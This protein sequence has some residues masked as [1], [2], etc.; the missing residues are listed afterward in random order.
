MK[1]VSLSY[2]ASF[3]ISFAAI[4]A[5]PVLG[6]TI[7][8]DDDQPADYPAIQPAIQAAVNGDTILVRDGTYTGAQNRALDFAGK[9]ITL[10]SE[11]GPANC[12]IDCES[13]ARAFYFHTSE[14]AAARLEG[15]TIRN[16]R[17]AVDG[18][19]IYIISASPTMV[20][21]VFSTNQ[22]VRYGGAIY[23]QS[24]SP[25]LDR[26][27][28]ETN[29]AQFGAGIFCNSATPKILDCVVSGNS[30]TDNGGGIHVWNNSN[31]TILRCRILENTS[32][33]HGGGIIFDTA[34]GTMT[35]SLLEDNHARYGGGIAVV[36]NAQP[37]ISRC[38]IRGNMSDDVGGGVYAVHAGAR[39]VISSCLI[40]VN[41]AAGHGAGICSNWAYPTL[42]NCT[43]A[44]NVSDAGSGGYCSYQYAATFS[45]CILWGNAPATNIGPATITYSDVQGGSAGTGNRDEDPLF[46]NAL[47]GEYHL[48]AGSPCFNVGNNAAAGIP[49][50]DLDGKMRAMGTA[51]DLGA[52][53]S[54][55]RILNVP[56]QYPTIQAGIDAATTGDTVL[57]ADGVYSEMVRL[58]NGKS[59]TVRSL[60]GPQNCILDG[61]WTNDY[62]VRF[63][64][65]NSTTVFRGFTVRGWSGGG[66]GEFEAPIFCYSASPTIRDCIIRDNVNSTG[67][68]GI[69][70]ISNSSPTIVDCT[71]MGNIGYNG[72]GILCWYSPAIITNCTIVN[73]AAYSSFGAI[74]AGITCASSGATITNTIVWGNATKQIH[75]IGS[76]APTVTYSDVQGGFAGTGNL[77]VDPQF[78]DATN[79]DYR[80]SELSGCLNRGNNGSNLFPTDQDGQ[81]RQR[82][83]Q[84]DL[85]AFEFTKI[86]RVPQEY[87]QIQPAIDAAVHGDTVLVA[88]GQY[89]G[90]LNFKGKAITI[91]SE[92]GPQFC[93]LDAGGTG[94]GVV[95]N[96]AETADAILEGLTITGGTVA[97]SGGGI[98]CDNDARP[99]LR[100]CIIKGNQAQYGGGLACL[101]SASPTLLN[102]LVYSNSA[103]QVGGGLFCDASSAL[104]LTHGTIADNLAA[105]YVTGGGIYLVPGG[106]VFVTNSIILHNSPDQVRNEGSPFALSM[107]FCNIQ[108]LILCM[109]YGNISYDLSFID[110]SAGNYRLIADTPSIGSG[111]A[112]GFGL[113]MTDLEG[114]NRYADGATDM[115]AYEYGHGTWNVPALIGTIQEAIDKA[116]YGDTVLVAPGTYPGGIDFKGKAITVQAKPGT[117]ECI[118][119]CGGAGVGVRFA[120]GER[121]GS[122]LSGFTILNANGTDGGAI[123]CM[124]ASPTIV[125]CILRNNAAQRGAGIF[126]LN[127]SPTVTNCTIVANTT[128]IAGG[129]IFSSGAVSPIVTNCILWDNLA[130]SIAADGVASVVT[131]SNVQ[132]GYAGT[133]NLNADPQFINASAGDYHLKTEASIQYLNYP[134]WTWKF[135]PTSPCVEAGSDTAAGLPTLDKEN[136]PRIYRDH[137]D[138]GAL[139]VQ[140]MQYAVQYQYGSIELAVSYARDGDTI[141]VGDGTFLG[142]V[143]FRGKKITLRSQNGPAACI[144]VG[145][146]GQGFIFQS[147]EGPDTV[148]SGFTI[149]N[150]KV[151]E[152]DGGG[153][154]CSG[155]S[156]TIDNCVIQGN[157]NHDTR[158]GGI[159]CSNGAA[160]M[161]RNCRI[162]GNNYTGIFCLDASPVINHCIISGHSYGGINIFGANGRPLILN[163]LIVGNGGGNFGGG[164]NV[165]FNYDDFANVTCVNSTITGNSTSGYGGG[166][167]CWRGNVQL[168]NTLVW[169]NSATLQ[170]DVFF[171]GSQGTLEQIRCHIG[172][173]DPKF[174]YAAAGDYRLLEGSPCF[175]AGQYDDRMT[176]TDL[177]GNPRVMYGTVDIGAYEL[178]FRPVV[179]GR[180]QISITPDT[181]V[182]EGAQWQLGDGQWHNPG[183]TVTGLV[184]GTYPIT[185]KPL[186][187]WIE[188]APISLWVSGDV[189]TTAS[190][191]YKSTHFTLGQI[192]AME[193]RQ[194]KELD[195][196]VR[197]EGMSGPVTYSYQIQNQPDGALSLDPATGRFVY[198]PSAQDTETISITLIASNGQQTVFQTMEITPI[199]DLP[200]EY[201]LFDEPTQP[202]PDPQ[203][204]DY[205]I[206]EVFNNAAEPFNNVNRTTRTINVLGKEI[207]IQ[208]G[209]P[210]NLFLYDNNEDIKSITFYAE[211]LIVRAP[212]RLPQTS[213]TIYAREV[214]FEGTAACID[215]TPRSLTQPA[216]GTGAAGTHGLK[217]G[218]ITL[219]VESV[220][221]E[222]NQPGR[223]I[224]K[225]GNGQMPGPG[226]NGADGASFTPLSSCAQPVLWPNTVSIQWGVNYCVSPGLVN[227]DQ[228]RGKSAVAAGKPG[229]GGAG[230]DLY[231]NIDLRSLV[232]NSGGSAQPSSSAQL[233]A[234]Y[235]RV[236]GNP[237]WPYPAFEVTLLGSEWWIYEVNFPGSNALAPEPA[238]WVGNTGQFYRVGH[239]LSWLHP[240]AVKM[241]VGYAKDAYLNKYYEQAKDIFDAYLD[242]LN[243]YMA[244]SMWSGVPDEQKQ[245]LEQLRDEILTYVHQLEC[246]LD[247]F[248]NPPGWAP[249]LSFEVTQQV[250][251]REVD[252][253]LQVLYLSYWLQTVMGTAAQESLGLETARST[254]KQQIDDFKAQY[255]SAVNLI[256]L[257]KTESQEISNRITTLQQRL[258]EKEQALLARAEANVK[259]RHKVPW[260]Q[261]AMRIA[262]SFLTMSPLAEGDWSGS[263]VAGTGTLLTSIDQ[264]FLSD[265]A[266]PTI[267]NQSDISKQFNGLNFSAA[268]NNWMT[269]GGVTIAGKSEAEL[270]TYLANL[271]NSASEIASN[272]TQ[273]KDTLKE[274]HVNNEEVQSELIKIKEADPEFSWLIDDVIELMTRK[275]LFGRQLAS[276]MHQVSSLS[277]D[278]RH[279]LI[280]IDALNRRVGEVAVILDQ[281]A[282]LYMKEMERRAR[283]RLLKYHYYLSKAYEY[284]LLEPY[285]EPLNLLPIFDR[286]KTIFS[287]NG[288]LSS[289]DFQALR[290]LLTDQLSTIADDILERFLDSRG[291]GELGTSF[292]FDLT[293]DEIQTLNTA[294]KTTINLYERGLFLSS[295]ED[296]RIVNLGVESLTP[297]N[298]Q[299]QCGVSYI[300]IYLEHS[301]VSRLMKNGKTYLFRH[302]RKDSSEDPSINKSVWGSTYD[303]NNHGFINPIAPSAASESLL[304]TVLGIASQNLMIYSRPSA[305]SDLAVRI[306]KNPGS[307]DD[308]LIGTLKLRVTY[309]YS[310]RSTSQVVLGVDSSQPDLAPYL[311]LDTA[312]LNGRK[313]GTGAFY[314]TYQKSSYGD[315]K[316]TILAPESVDGW[317]FQKWTRRNGSDLPS[318]F[319]TSDPLQIKVPLD[320]SY[321]VR[322]Q[323]QYLGG[324]VRYGDGDADQDVDMADLG[325]I[326][327]YWMR[328][329]GPGCGECDKVDFNDDGQIDLED[330]VIFMIHWLQ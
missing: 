34:S 139:E 104:T 298:P 264:Q 326:S 296:I 239:S 40:V 305:W 62:M 256:P 72:A 308:I 304:R 262:G 313:D 258:R 277:N 16:G 109:G 272:M 271:R 217:G 222:G 248:G 93:I 325:L 51:V 274:T 321:S 203:S 74:G 31:P 230:G 193:I 200:E 170:P 270:K 105:G 35:D 57:V 100:N 245:E 225:G 154:Y 207:V 260:W 27:R 145:G 236:G 286:F 190:A 238:L 178:E 44:G 91:R 107:S 209:N 218:S 38:I 127:A 205:I 311:I 268:V 2:L 99:T 147:G 202:L 317:Q 285:P 71:I 282:K 11:N 244:S 135:I 280:S 152:G 183:E 80:L 24:A 240:H 115:G 242:P 12:I 269:D 22:A 301:G 49:A 175:N 176:D 30:A 65:V 293:A 290:P 41:Y 144:V 208:S 124:N 156:P 61:S 189:L 137:A 136:H 113:P 303:H 55:P 77:N 125:N 23:I 184:S 227:Y 300:K 263:L 261:K 126:S 318:G 192:P 94:P 73:N 1:G 151:W 314:R 17:D 315:K 235:D 9:A 194:G 3:C 297:Q 163:T 164:I 95:F 182:Q 123:F 15:L 220:F 37:S 171:Y 59:I 312:D 204:D 8:V 173:A 86:R 106:R 276:A 299:A 316:V 63:T 327:A 206:K 155:A 54:G 212:F 87:A 114:R 131:Y 64:Q 42:V 19:G 278:I 83:G 119:D 110:P 88:D 25:T 243:Q 185:F 98:L 166:I 81:P 233:H 21:C 226:Q 187:G 129:G 329:A 196:Q 210:N 128:S 181:A 306:E 169:G 251:E 216:Q 174:R 229:N 259:E 215:T 257:L 162:S 322:A 224:L 157:F 148:I 32:P 191:E 188:P 197:A 284:R 117:E 116:C 241:A 112:D 45:N 5:F 281:R 97:G 158:G 85:G 323:Y 56:Q 69:L 232:S 76:P 70:C 211:K 60:N 13:A 255:T 14:T 66:L 214:R 122:V 132:G 165:G 92:Y 201:D 167:H 133:G 328:Q 6:G 254:L 96:S 153:I 159:F 168:V 265:A 294:G 273:I 160:P 250:Y 138:M 213:V 295:E 101:N 102:C 253:A 108:G 53:E 161:I 219:N 84:I 141:T 195:F 324:L 320:A 309:D 130:Q 266:W 252:R 223:F 180:L 237:G 7:T 36:Y 287:T 267:I 234:Q 279:N 43:L 307:C 199:V 319:Y 231:S 58:E 120:R 140:A 29:T 67:S 18:G 46:G 78:A 68:A 288:Q 179:F 198:T 48:L 134:Y 4:G 79:G 172:G 302:Y 28:I 221:S 47:Y 228:I 33:Q 118:I 103:S 10:R 20:R 283:N 50:Q 186:P 142:R 39:P 121:A 310:T 149:T 150:C 246:G 111:R 330:L 247:F 177:A 143:D 291:G 52:Y 75:A 82:Y 146:D 90:N 26:C 89:A 249:M 289:T 275:E 292:T